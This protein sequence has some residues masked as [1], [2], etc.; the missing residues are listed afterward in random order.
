MN[1]CATKIITIGHYLS[2]AN[3]TFHENYSKVSYNNSAYYPNSGDSKEIQAHYGQDLW[4]GCHLCYRDY[5]G[6][7]RSTQ[8]DTALDSPTNQTFV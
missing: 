3:K 5:V 6:K 4:Y 1:M 2:P 8:Q 7:V